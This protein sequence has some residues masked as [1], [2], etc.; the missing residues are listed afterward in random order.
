[1]TNVVF[2]TTLPINGENRNAR[3]M[4]RACPCGYPP[5][6][7]NSAP[8]PP[9][10]AA[11]LSAGFQKHCYFA[12]ILPKK[13]ALADD[14]G[15][16]AWHFEFQTTDHLTSTDIRDGQVPISPCTTKGLKATRV[17]SNT[18]AKVAKLCRSVAHSASLYT[19]QKAQRETPWTQSVT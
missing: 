3:A 17:Y 12:K 8:R 14:F 9:W 10:L 1:M 18:S 7:H 6:E 15:T 2:L 16:L 4:Y 19:L 5:K 11:R 13:H